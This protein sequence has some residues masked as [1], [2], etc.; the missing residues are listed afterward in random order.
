MIT[1][2]QSIST[3]VIGGFE[4]VQSD[5]NKEK[6]ETGET[7]SK[8]ILLGESQKSDTTAENNKKT[9]KNKDSSNNKP[10]FKE[11]A[12]KVKTVLNDEKLS[13]EFTIDKD[14]KKMIMKIID[15]ETKE[16]VQQYPPEISLKIAR[17]VSS[18]IENGH[19]TNAKV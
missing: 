16:V 7:L 14:T 12:D 5:F 19:V 1:S 6:K 18:S 17:I 2:V 9:E 15:S 13:I 4:K 8:K 10:T 11:L 3:V